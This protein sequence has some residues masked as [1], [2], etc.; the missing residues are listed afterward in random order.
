MGFYDYNL[1]VFVVLIAGF[2]YS[3]YKRDVVSSR[4]RENDSEEG[5]NA[6]I[7]SKAVNW[8]FKKRFLPVYLLVNGADWL[9]VKST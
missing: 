4:N 7:A 3:Q 1:F 5:K 2:G 6:R 8:Q 9:Q